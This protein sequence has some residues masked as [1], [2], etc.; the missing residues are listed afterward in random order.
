MPFSRNQIRRILADNILPD[1]T[2]LT[3]SQQVTEAYLRRLLYRWEDRA[4]KAM[5]KL[6]RAAW[7]DIISTSAVIA[8][9]ANIGATLTTANGLR[10][11]DAVY[12]ELQRRL[13]QLAR[14]VS[15]LA[16]ERA[17][18][19][20]HGGYLGKAWAL[21]TTTIDSAP[22]PTPKPISAYETERRIMAEW[23][24]RFGDEWAA[25]FYVPF[26]QF[27][28]RARSALT[29]AVTTDGKTT[30]DGLARVKELM[31]VTTLGGLYAAAQANVRTAIMMAGNLGGLA[32]ALEHQPVRE[33]VAGIGAIAVWVTAGDGKVCPDCRPY[34]G[35]VWRL[36]TIA[37][38]IGA[39]LTKPTP[40]LH[41]NCRCTEVVLALPEWL[42]PPDVPPGLTM[43]EWLTLFGLDALLDPFMSGS[44]MD[45]S[46]IGEV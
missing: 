33:A 22:K 39:S 28:M 23:E 31:G 38:L 34:A 11:R 19:A 3:L 12:A 1:D 10:W 9:R 14:D 35:R 45:T 15:A 40:P 29:A 24:A 36:D 37:G 44:T 26:L 43:S 6:F 8:D 21:Y 20:Y 16:L 27:E 5:D 18:Y 30:A 2:P 7:Q 42:L 4:V 32:L 17:V 46:R 25:A 13:G 41:H